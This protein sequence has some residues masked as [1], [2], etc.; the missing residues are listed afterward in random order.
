MFHCIPFL[1]TW[2]RKQSRCKSALA[3][4]QLLFPVAHSRPSPSVVS[5]SL[6]TMSQVQTWWEF[7][8]LRALRASWACGSV[9]TT[10][11]NVFSRHVFSCFFSVRFSHHTTGALCS[12]LSLLG[13]LL[14]LFHSLSAEQFGGLFLS[15]D[16]PRPSPS[17][18]QCSNF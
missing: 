17:L 12:P 2:L 7:L 11:L 18:L 16:Q 4:L 9:C 10:H 5:C 1:L 8:G 14:C 15:P 6:N 13:N 3:A